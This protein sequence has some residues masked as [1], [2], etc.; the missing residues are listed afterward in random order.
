MSDLWMRQR[1]LLWQIGVAQLAHRSP[2]A[3]LRV[4]LKAYFNRED[5]FNRKKR[6][7]KT[8]RECQW[9]MDLID[10]EDADV[11]AALA[12]KIFALMPV[13][14]VEERAVSVTTWINSAKRSQQGVTM[15]S[16]HLQ[17]RQFQ[18]SDVQNDR[19]NKNQLSIRWRDMQ[20]T[21]HKLTSAEGKPCHW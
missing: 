4:Q 6:E 16:N 20:S 8:A 14:M 18:Q 15:V 7:N 17:I 19:R 11:L 2:A 12:V 3:A 1:R 9:W 10:H 5:P 21:I 13:S